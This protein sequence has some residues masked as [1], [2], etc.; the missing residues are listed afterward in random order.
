VTIVGI[1]PNPASGK[2]IRRLVGHALVVGNREKSNIVRRIL[3]GLHASKVNDV[4]IMPDKFGI[5]LLAIDDLKNRWAD[6]VKGAH[7]MDMEFTGT[8]IDSIRAARFLKNDHAACIITLGGDGTV[9]L[10][11]KECGDVPLLPVSTGTNN[12]LPMFIEGTVAG[13]AAG[14]LAQQEQGERE[15]LCFRHK[16]MDIYVNGKMADIALIDVAAVEASFAGAK[17]VWE[18]SVF[19]QIFVTR[20]SPSSIGLSSILGMVM[21]V[22]INDPFGA[23]T[24]FGS[25]GDPQQV[26]APVGPGLI[27]E[28]ALQSIHKMEPDTPYPVVDQRPLMLALDGEREIYLGPDDKAEILLRASGPWIVD[29]DRVMQDVVQNQYYVRMAKLR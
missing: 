14:Y 25:E 24:I 28:L 26:T 8:G 1:I 20:A 4:R 13:M 19:K 9:R 22:S 6:V 3:I 18:A 21:P 2:D 17:A 23:T 7:V 5:G 15:R 16:R 10:V 11:A 29:I 12:V 27:T